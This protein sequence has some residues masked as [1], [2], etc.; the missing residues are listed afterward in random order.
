MSIDEFI[1]AA[2]LYTTRGYDETHHYSNGIEVRLST[3]MSAAIE[4]KLFHFDPT[5]PDGAFGLIVFENTGI[6][7]GLSWDN[8]EAYARGPDRPS[9]IMLGD[10]VRGMLQEAKAVKDLGLA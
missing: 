10:L 2:E 4:L 3:L 7:T 6:V 8:I 1:E 5:E 9:R